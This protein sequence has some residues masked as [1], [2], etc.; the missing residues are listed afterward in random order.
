VIPPRPNVGK[1]T[2]VSYEIRPS[3]SLEVVATATFAMGANGTV[4]PDTSARGCDPFP[5]PVQVADV[6]EAWARKVTD[7]FMFAVLGGQRIPIPD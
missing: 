7:I 2:A 4:H 6:E 1:D 5:A 3:G